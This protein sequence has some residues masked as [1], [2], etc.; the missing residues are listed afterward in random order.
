M[1]KHFRAIYT[2][3]SRF[4]FFRFDERKI[5][6]FVGIGFQL[7]GR[8]FLFPIPGNP[9]APLKNSTSPNL[10]RS[11]NDQNLKTNPLMFYEEPRS[12]YEY[13][14][15]SS[16]LASAE[17]FPSFLKRLR[18]F[19]TRPLFFRGRIRPH[20]HNLLCL[21]ISDE[22]FL[23]ASINPD[24]RNS[25]CKSGGNSE[26]GCGLEWCD[27]MPALTVWQLFG[28]IIIGSI[29]YPYAVAITQSLFSKIIGP[30]PQVRVTTY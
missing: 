10:Y 16:K 9:T 21:G 8:I 25:E 5:L 17:A 3:C 27:S 14:S 15:F 19:W 18:F 7:L 13:Q 20:R 28:G 26:P 30:R 24:T 29:G 11:I 12:L 6:L 4:F 2:W 23:R 22:I 1:E